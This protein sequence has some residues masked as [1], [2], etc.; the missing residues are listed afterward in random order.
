MALKKLYDE[1]KSDK[2]NQVKSPETYSMDLE[3]FF[4]EHVE[5]IK[6]LRSGSRDELLKEADDQEK[7]LEGCLKQHGMTM[8]DV[9]DEHGDYIEP[10]GP[11]EKDDEE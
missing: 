1:V 5:L 4:E 8:A 7:E 11:E 3:D 10:D 6:I 2:M 9:R